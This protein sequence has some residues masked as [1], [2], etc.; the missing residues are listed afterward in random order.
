M[1][2]LKQMFHMLLC[3]SM[4]SCEEKKEGAYDLRISHLLGL[5]ILFHVVHEMREMQPPSIAKEVRFSP[6]I[7]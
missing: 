6:L 7:S 4:H 2:K 5:R 3:R 1:D